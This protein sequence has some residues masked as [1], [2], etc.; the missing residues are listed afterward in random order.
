MSKP[1]IFRSGG[2][3]WVACKHGQNTGPYT[4]RRMA[5][6]AAVMLWEEYGPAVAHS[7]TLR[8]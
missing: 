2:R 6:R 1:R 8:P 7:P 4:D 3:W 5:F